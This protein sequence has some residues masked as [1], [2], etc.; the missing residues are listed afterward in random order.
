MAA[1]ASE[2]EN[3]GSGGLCRGVC[4]KNS[5]DTAVSSLFNGFGNLGKSGIFSGFGRILTFLLL[6]SPGV[7]ADVNPTGIRLFLLFVVRDSVLPVFT[8]G[9]D[10]GLRCR[11]GL[12]LWL[13]EDVPCH[14]GPSV[15]SRTWAEAFCG[16]SPLSRESKT[17]ESGTVLGPAQPFVGDGFFIDSIVWYSSLADLFPRADVAGDPVIDAHVAL[18]PNLPRAGESQL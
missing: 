4:E 13:L 6:P 1:P 15:P 17:L 14:G 7:V 11:C 16:L 3:R 8:T 9:S 10:T 18:V 12:V 2:L 5:G